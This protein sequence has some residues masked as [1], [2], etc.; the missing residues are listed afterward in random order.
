MIHQTVNYL[1]GLL[2]VLGIATTYH[3]VTEL[4]T[5]EDR[6][7]NER[8]VP[9]V[10]VS[11]GNFDEVDFES[12]VLYHRITGAISREEE[13]SD[14][15]CGLNITQTA[16]MRLVCFFDKAI[17]KTDDANITSKIGNNIA[18]TIS[19]NN[20]K[21]LATALQT[22][23]VEV[24]VLSI[25]T[26][27]RTIF[28]GEFD[29]IDYTLP[30][31]LGVVSIDY[32]I[33]VSGDESCFISYGCDDESLDIRQLIIDEYCI[34]Q[35]T[36]MIKNYITTA[37]ATQTFADFIGYDLDDMYINLQGAGNMGSLSGLS[38]AR[39]MVTAWDSV[40]GIMTF[41]AAL[42]AGYQITIIG[43]N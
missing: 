17:Y 9:L 33:R 34:T 39:K 1:N 24:S 6:E 12:K 25:E 7:G 19:S 29:G 37:S 20:I 13:E 11:R 26:N 10:Y 36:T 14:V 21:S 22:D 30:S 15:G 23:Y 40:T 2:E 43:T 38:A 27:R 3:A 31:D 16:P 41:K 32:E 5:V 4:E 8:T 42:S 35:S 18:N 28:D